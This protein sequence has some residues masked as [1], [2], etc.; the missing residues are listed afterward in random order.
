MTCN[1]RYRVE[2]LKT[3]YLIQ[4][5]MEASDQM[6]W[7]TVHKH[8]SQTAIKE[9]MWRRTGGGKGLKNNDLL[10]RAFKELE[11]EGLVTVKEGKQRA[12]LYF[13]TDRGRV[14]GEASLNHEPIP[15][16]NLTTRLTEPRKPLPTRNERLWRAIMVGVGVWLF[17][18][19]ILIHHDMPDVNLFLLIPITLMTVLLWPIKLSTAM[20]TTLVFHIWNLFMEPI[21]RSIRWGGA[22]IVDCYDLRGIVLFILLGV[23]NTVSA[24]A[25][26]YVRSL[27]PDKLSVKLTILL[28][29]NEHRWM[30]VMAVF[31][32]WMVY[33]PV[34]LHPDLRGMNQF[35]LIGLTL[36]AM[37]RSPIKLT[38]AWS[39]I[40]VFHI[41]NLFME[42]LA[43]RILWGGWNWLWFLHAGPYLLLV[44][45]SRSFK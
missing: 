43:H 16:G 25:I 29:S 27:P 37:Q 13:L 28:P 15:T 6:D 41:L 10:V 42:P 33:S 31:G 35:V 5:Q 45:S 9:E 34:F 23:I 18:S 26:C 1:E 20:G 24:G 2:I 38:T 12:K 14:W 19:P 30:T 3:I 8:L 40:L 36:I 17:C 22:C 21:A 39:T 32:T 11:E 44:V 4:T 7:E